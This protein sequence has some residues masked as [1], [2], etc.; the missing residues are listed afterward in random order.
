VVVHPPKQ[1][2]TLRVYLE[3]WPSEDPTELIR[4]AVHN[5]FA[6]RTKLNDLEFTRLMRQGRTSLLIG[7]PFLGA[8]LLK[9]IAAGRRGGYLCG[10]TAGESD[11]RGLGRDVAADADIPLRLVASAPA[12][13]GLREAKSDSGRSHS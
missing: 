4:E 3:Q 8:C 11:H 7:L 1:T 9:Q 12:G 2:L 10:V 5:Y 6:Y 13:P